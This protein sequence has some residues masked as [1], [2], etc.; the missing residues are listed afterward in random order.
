M[1]NG[2]YESSDVRVPSSLQVADMKN[3]EHDHLR[4]RLYVLG[5]L[6]LA[7]LG[8]TLAWRWT[9]LREWLDI[10]RIVMMLRQIGQ[11]FGPVAAIAGVTLGCTIGV[12]LTFLSMVSIV[13]FGPNNGALYLLTGACLGS[14]ISYGIGHRLG[15]EAIKGL[16]GERVND[17]S[18]RLGRK[19]IVAGFTMRMIPVAPFAV[20]NM[21]AGSSHIRL[22]EFL[23][24]STLGMLPG[25]LLMATFVDTLLAAVQT[26]SIVS[27]LLAMLMLALI[28]GGLWA[29]RRWLKRNPL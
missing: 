24:G 10:N 23:L 15:S 21:I 16:A 6:L 11:N 27:L 22:W 18:T 4:R 3:N 25:T 13:A 12:P 14:A 2:F 5:V 17:I 1:S 20:L 26:P 19:G 28:L 29:A 8:L 9:P 7:L